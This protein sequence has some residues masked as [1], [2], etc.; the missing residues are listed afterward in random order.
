MKE[1][2]VK[3]TDFQEAIRIANELA[4]RFFDSKAEFSETCKNGLYVIVIKPRAMRRM[5]K[6]CHPKKNRCLTIRRDG[7]F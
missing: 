7:R 5:A 1:M 2:V 4:A 3:S 6:R